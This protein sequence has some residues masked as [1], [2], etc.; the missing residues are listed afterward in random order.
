[1]RIYFFDIYEVG[2]IDI[3]GAG[4]IRP[5]FS[6]EVLDTNYWRYGYRLRFVVVHIDWKWSCRGGRVTKRQMFFVSDEADR[7]FLSSPWSEALELL[8]GKIFWNRVLDVIKRCAEFWRNQVWWRFADLELGNVGRI[9]KSLGCLE[10][11]LGIF[12]EKK[13]EKRRRMLVSYWKS[14]IINQA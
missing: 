3:F 2:R 6:V 10:K 7:Y 12:C 8:L 1:M 14:C 13:N 9:Y 5:V 11:K 4:R